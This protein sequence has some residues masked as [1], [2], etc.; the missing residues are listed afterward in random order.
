MAISMI[1]TSIQQPAYM[2][3]WNSGAL[4]QAVQL[5][6]GRSAVELR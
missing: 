4:V 3:G 6:N 1:T 2:E 5:G